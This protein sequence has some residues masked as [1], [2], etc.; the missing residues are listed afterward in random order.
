MID[1]D[2]S[3]LRLRDNFEDAKNL[4]ESPSIDIFYAG[5][6]HLLPGET[7]LQITN[8][9]TDIAFSGNFEVFLVDD[10]NND[11][12]NITANVAIQQ[13]IDR[14]GV[15]QIIWEWVNNS[16]IPNRLVSLRF[17]NTVNN[18]TWWTNLF[19]S[20]A[21]RQRFTARYDY[22]S[23]AVYYGTDYGNADF[24][25]SIR[26]STYFNNDVNE[27]TRTEYHQISTDITLS[28]RNVRD[29]REQYICH[30]FNQFTVRRLELM[31]TSDFVYIDN[32]RTFSSTPIEFIEREGD[33]DY[34]EYEMIVNKNYAQLFTFN[35]QIHIPIA[36]TSFNPTG[37]FVT[38]STFNTFSIVFN[39]TI[40]LEQGSIT[41]FD[42]GSNTAIGQFD[43]SLMSLAG[44]NTLNIDVSGNSDVQSPATG[45]Y[46]V[47][48][49]QGLVNW[50]GVEPFEGVD[51]ATTWTFSLGS[52]DFIDTDFNDNDFFTD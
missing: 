10:C 18:D 33:S 40:T 14:N 22:K 38:G 27:S 20:T 49:S 47:Q 36:V 29:F 15:R 51:D 50:L 25:Q 44:A 28:G 39:D 48:V 26:L 35:Y 17:R 34:A 24:Y 6:V 23:N 31:I 30:Q 5:Q 9:P 32:V 12:E 37:S 21:Q 1:R 42:A 7:Y 13:F 19:L 4:N 52:A 8:S 45:N 41:V 2:Y 3:F 46:Y 16:E 43:Q 11:V